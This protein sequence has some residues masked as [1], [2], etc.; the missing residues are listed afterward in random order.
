MGWHPT[1]LRAQ[2]HVLIL[3]VSALQ[4]IHQ[5][6]LRLQNHQ[7]RHQPAKRFYPVAGVRADVKYKAADWNR[8]PEKP[9]QLCARLA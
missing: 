8:A 7:T 5:I 1:H 4:K 2:H 3:P 9:T 6:R